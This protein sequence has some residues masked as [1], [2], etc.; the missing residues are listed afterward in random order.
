[1]DCGRYALGAVQ[2]PW[3]DCGRRLARESWF[4]DKVKLRIDLPFA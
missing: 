2:L 3:L 1:M 4:L